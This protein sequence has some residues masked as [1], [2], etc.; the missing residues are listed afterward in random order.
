[1]N[2]SSKPRRNPSA[3]W[4]ELD[5]E[6]AIISGDGAKLHMLNEVGG[7]IWTLLDGEQD[8]EA[9]ASFVATE[10]AEERSTVAREA[11]EFVINLKD[12]NLVENSKNG[13]M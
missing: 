9:I 8:L 13:S 5:G 10:F 7:R 6:T 11:L 4:R 2:M 12:L 3:I 1:M